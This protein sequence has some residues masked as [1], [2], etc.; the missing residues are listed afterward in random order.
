ML[1]SRTNR[2]PRRA[3]V[4]VLIAAQVVLLGGGALGAA[5]ISGQSHRLPTFAVGGAF[6]REGSAPTR[7]SSEAGPKATSATTSAGPPTPLGL[8]EPGS[9]PAGSVAAAARRTTGASTAARP[10]DVNASGATVPAVG[11]YTYDISGQESSTG[12]GGRSFPSTMTVDVH[13]ST[14][15]PADQVVLDISFSSQ[16]QEREILQ[17]DQRGIS[18]VYE[19]GAVTF[20]PMTQTNQATYVPAMVQVPLPDEAGALVSGTSAAR[21]SDGSTDR[22]EDWTTSV[23]GVEA[24]RTQSGYRQCPVVRIDRRTRPGSADQETRRVTYWYDP[25]TGIWDRWSVLMHAQR[26][27]VGFT[28]TYDENFTATLSSFQAA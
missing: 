20:G 2:P 5:R 17:Y 9:S 22:V 18:M 23:Q 24:V 3:V 7:S 25:G 21:N 14:G 28:F 10:E 8:A 27:Y 6:L 15:L 4:A 16:H 13:R 1:S 19:A 26:S 12:F 11:V